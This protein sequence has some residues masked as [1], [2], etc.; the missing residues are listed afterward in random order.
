MTVIVDDGDHDDGDDEGDVVGGV[1]GVG[2]RVQ[3][4]SNYLLAGPQSNNRQP[5]FSPILLRKTTHYYF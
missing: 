2:G 4:V 5:D 3:P 1:G